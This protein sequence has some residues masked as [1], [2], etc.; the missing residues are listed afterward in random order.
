MKYTGRITGIVIM[1]I[2]IVVIRI[3][4]YF[5]L[6]YSFSHLPIPGIIALIIVFWAGKQYDKVKFYS[7]KDSLTGLYNRRFVSHLLPYLL[8]QMDRKS[9][10]L[11][12]AIWD[13][14][15]F[16]VINDKHGH[17]TGDL[18]LQEF[19]HLLVESV[20]KS[21][22]VARWGGDEFLLIA[23]YA[24]KAAIKVIM[25]RFENELQTLSN[26]LQMDISATC[27]Y[28]IYPDDAKTIDALISMADTKMYERKK[29]SVRCSI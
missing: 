12:I 11:G 26:K 24:D 19:S 25:S 6:Q 15:N 2:T 22:I 27:G 18:V 20:R 3:Y 21:D 1:L 23:P 17:L 8:A 14:D 9:T 7:E 29:C 4:A 16:K 28:V 10:K 13:C 5:Y